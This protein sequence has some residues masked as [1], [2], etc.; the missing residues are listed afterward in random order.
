MRKS[1]VELKK[2]VTRLETIPYGNCIICDC[3][4]KVI[5]DSSNKDDVCSKD[6]SYWEVKTGHHD[7][8]NDSVIDN[9]N[10]DICSPECLHKVLG[11][12]TRNIEGHSTYYI[13]I[14]QKVHYASRNFDDVSRYEN[15]NFTERELIGKFNDKCDH[16]NVISVEDYSDTTDASK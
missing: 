5:Y 10:F 11:Q 16:N 14:K 6:I 2:R 3:C 9:E 12:Y 4:R 1:K 7:Y 15:D 13:K 8:G